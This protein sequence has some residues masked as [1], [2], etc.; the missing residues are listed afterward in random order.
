MKAIISFIL[1]FIAIKC[2]RAACLEMKE[3]TSWWCMW[4]IFAIFAIL[5]AIAL[6]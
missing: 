5:G 2:I 3:G 1:F 4:G 6:F